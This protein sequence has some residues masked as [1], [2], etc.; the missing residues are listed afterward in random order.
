MAIS[1]RMLISLSTILLVFTILAIS[2][3]TAFQARHPAK[4]PQL[5]LAEAAKPGQAEP[6]IKGK[7][8]GTT[9][10]R[11][12]ID[13][14]SATSVAWAAIISIPAI[15]RSTSVDEGFIGLT[16]TPQPPRTTVDE[17][18]IGPIET[19][20]APIPPIPSPAGPQFP[21]LALSYT[22][23]GGP[24]HCRG[25]LIHELRIPPPASAHK[26]G[27]CVDLPTMARCG[28]F[29]AGKDDNC[30]AELFNMPGCLN[31]TRSYVN[32]VVFMPE[33]RVVGALWKS[34]W[35]RC[36]IDAPEAGLL[37]PSVLGD[38]L[39]KPGG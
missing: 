37:D 19:E 39:V 12:D 18:Y 7:T 28:V 25:E 21:I 20:Q 13:I 5:T 11:T 24:K 15:S 4:I 31:T 38:L 34:M 32:T 2:L 23:S 35:V 30:E 14:E 33:E 22:G 6:E 17:G 26:N 10:D 27:S 29:F 16:P 36:G 8:N 3:S 1:R 9:L